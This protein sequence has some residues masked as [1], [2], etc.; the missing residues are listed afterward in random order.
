MVEINQESEPVISTQKITE[1]RLEAFIN[2][3]Y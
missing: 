3:Q 2:V 1:T